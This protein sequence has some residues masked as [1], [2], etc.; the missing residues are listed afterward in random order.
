MSD[1]PL[2]VYCRQRPVE[3]AWR[4]FCSERCK[5][6]DLGH[7]LSGNYRAPVHENDDDTEP[8]APG[9]STGEPDA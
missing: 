9:V 7:W 8:E 3:I 6:A 5:M 2:C 1:V 4:P